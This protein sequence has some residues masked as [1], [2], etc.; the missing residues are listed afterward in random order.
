MSSVPRLF[1]RTSAHDKAACSKEDTLHII[2]FTH[3]KR[4]HAH[5]YPHA[6]VKLKLS[7]T[8]GR[9]VLHSSIVEIYSH[10]PLDIDPVTR[11]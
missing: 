7:C 5:V 2:K 4:V 11:I 3:I 8:I 1:N 9:Y 10:D 6:C